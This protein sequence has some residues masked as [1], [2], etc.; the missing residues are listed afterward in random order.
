MKFNKWIPALC[1]GFV[2]QP[3]GAFACRYNVRDIGFI[4][5]DKSSYIL[6]GFLSGG[7]PTGVVETFTTVTD[8]ALEQCNIR[9]EY[10]D[11]KNQSQHPALE[12]L[13]ARDASSLPAF[14]LVS[15][16]G[17]STPVTISKADELVPQELSAALAPIIS[18]STRNE[19]LEKICRTF[20][21]ILLIE[22]TD[23]DANSQ[24]H[25]AIQSSITRIQEQM[26]WMPKAIAQPP[27]TVVINPES[28]S[29][30]KTL[31]WS[32]GL[33]TKATKDPRAAVIYGKARWIG[34]IM[35]GE[36]ITERNLV[37]VFSI[38]GADCECSFDISWTQGT[39]LPVKWDRIRHKQVV[40]SLGFD[41][42]N[43]MIKTEASR[44]LGRGSPSVSTADKYTE[45]PEASDTTS[46]P[47]PEMIVAQASSVTNEI[48]IRMPPGELNQGDTEPI[49]K[50]LWIAMGG[51]VI[52]VGI[53]SMSI[54]S[55]AKSRK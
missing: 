44:I 2:L 35:N 27:E 16:D 37:G 22:G 15:P 10:I 43:P 18:S 29:E 26:K 4:D 9:A 11:V 12:Y 45:T 54:L 50:K 30:E 31:L 39:R 48:A 47:S 19:I 41:P 23:S 49:F 25:E 14:V 24:A 40:A 36:E 53:A 13:S 28:F 3:G 38:I 7:A 32:L 46:T 52:L 6:Y 20:G 17:Q 8:S 34:P 5:L 33:E 51:I 42:E 1:L 55:R 21:V